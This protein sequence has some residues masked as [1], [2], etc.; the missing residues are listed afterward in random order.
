MEISERFLLQKRLGSQRKRKFGEIFLASDK[1]TGKAVVLKTI[2]LSENDAT[3]IDR[4]RAEATFSFDVQGLPTTIFYEETETGVFLVR[5]FHE[6]IPL[7]AFWL[8]IKKRHRLHF[9]IDLLKKL[10]PIFT[11]LEACRIVHCDIKPS[12][13]LISPSDNDSFDVHL[14]DFGLAIR[15]DETETNRARKL[16]F[17]LGY[18]APELLLNRLELVDQRT[19]LFALGI[20]IWRLFSGKLPLTHPNPSIF[21]NLQLTHPLPENSAISRNLQRILVK[22]CS[23]HA[24]DLPP[25]RMNYEDVN[26]KLADAMQLRYTSIKEVISDFEALK[27]KRFWQ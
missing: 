11:H 2:R 10:E 9:L 22:M 14:L 17:P 1:L 13:L 12:N 21:T 23:K 8:T 27:K 4:L 5:D 20:V 15:M 7:D 26:E 3:A 24:F 19:D 6:G 16:L 18:A 25:N